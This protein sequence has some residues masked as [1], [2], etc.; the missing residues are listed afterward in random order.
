MINGKSHSCMQEFSEKESR[1]KDKTRK[2][3]QLD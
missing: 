2:A 3:I 1:R